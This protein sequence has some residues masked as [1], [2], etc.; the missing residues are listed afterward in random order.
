MLPIV[1]L[2]SA[3]ILRLARSEG[4][5][6]TRL[7]FLVRRPIATGLTFSIRG[8]AILWLRLTFR[9]AWALL[10]LGFAIAAIL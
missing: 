7:V 8:A 4:L 6:G 1:V 3:G 10:A 9:L 2:G 5:A